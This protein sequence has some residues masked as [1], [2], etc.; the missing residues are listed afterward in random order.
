MTNIANTSIQ[1]DSLSDQLS[2][3]L[4][5]S[6]SPSLSLQWLCELPICSLEVSIFNHLGF[7]YKLQ[8]QCF[9]I[10]YLPYGLINTKLV[11]SPP[12]LCLFC[13]RTS[14][15]SV[16]F[17]QELAGKTTSFDM[18]NSGSTLPLQTIMVG[19]PSIIVLF[20]HYVHTKKLLGLAYIDIS[21]SL[22]FLS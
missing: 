5:A 6:S 17:A 15:D 19:S 1:V 10:K 8:G 14:C 18:K 16:C 13:F 22:F 7:L 4:L 12:S 2:H 9:N 21:H 20:P 3:H 11:G